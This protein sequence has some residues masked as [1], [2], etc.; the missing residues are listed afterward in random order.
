MDVYF[1]CVLIPLPVFPVVF[2]TEQQLHT[3]SAP[4]PRIKHF[5][6]PKA[7]SGLKISG[8]KGRAEKKNVDSTFRSQ[9]NNSCLPQ[10]EREKERD[11]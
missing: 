4:R 9:V 6:R 1:M 10:R 7:N 5:H 2:A 8:G 11:C 3:R